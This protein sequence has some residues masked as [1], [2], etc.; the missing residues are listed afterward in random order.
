MFRS[1][2]GF[3]DLFQAICHPVTILDNDYTIL[4]A[5][6]ATFDVASLS[7]KELIGKKCYQM[8]HAS[9]EPPENCPCKKMKQTMHWEM[10]EM[11]VETLGRTYLASCA[12]LLDS[13]GN[14]Q[15]VV[16]L[17]T[18][19]DA[20]KQT[21][22]NLLQ[23]VSQLEAFKYLAMQIG[24]TLS[25]REEI[26]AALL[27]LSKLQVADMAVVYLLV[28]DSLVFMGALPEVDGLPVAG[29]SVKNINEC[30]CGMAALGE[31]V[32]S[33]AIQTD[34][35]CTLEDCKRAGM[36]SFAAL[37]LKNGD[38]NIGV[39]G[40]GSKCE[41][42]FT[43]Q[44]Q[45]VEA[46]AVETSIGLINAQLYQ[47]VQGHTAEL[48]QAV[49]EKTESLRRTLKLMAGRENRMAELKDVIRQ[50]RTQ[51]IEAGLNPVADDPLKKR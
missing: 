31:P 18:D 37:P 27:E 24:R 47:E 3:Q 2:V 15:Q 32:Y 40:L 6:Q 22:E 9:D 21:E 17:L 35:R 44:K 42:A 19:I 10:S 5:N 38:D 14:L 8:F 23:S 20:H 28:D 49:D 43:E 50:L 11:E 7:S 45:F 34:N 39:L 33:D 16:H 46:L 51:L 25:V 4:N 29:E 1:E 13:E 48:E 30:L 41:A 36:K 12:P 26:K